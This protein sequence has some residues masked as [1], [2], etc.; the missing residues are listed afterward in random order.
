VKFFSTVAAA[1]ASLCAVAASGSLP[2][3]NAMPASWGQMAQ[4]P[5]PL[6]DF[7]LIDHNGQTLSR[8]DM[9]GHVWVASF[10]LVHR[11]I[12]S[13][14]VTQRL[15]AVANRVP[16]ADVR[17]V[18]FSIDPDDAPPVLDRFRQAVGAADWRWRFVA[19]DEVSFPEIAD[20]LGLHAS[21]FDVPARFLVIDDGG[22]VRASF[23][24][25]DDAQLAQ[26][27]ALLAT[28]NPPSAGGF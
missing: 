15:R 27:T 21:P 20:A 12:A 22:I 2:V 16:Q 8:A 19:A 25:F 1:M 26:L 24:A 9:L 10:V 6:P 11:G 28:F 17:F 23:D 14:V 18:S 4:I 7:L 3:R 13:A 5:F